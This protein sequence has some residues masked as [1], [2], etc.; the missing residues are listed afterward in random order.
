MAVT[1]ATLQTALR[2]LGTE[3]QKILDEHPETNTPE[4][5]ARAR[6]QGEAIAPTLRLLEA[7][8]QLRALT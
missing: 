7:V 8:A 3:A 5:R 4:K 6:A 2:S 1:L